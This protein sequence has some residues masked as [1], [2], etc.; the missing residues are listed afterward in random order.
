MMHAKPDTPFPMTPTLKFHVTTG[1]YTVGEVIDLS[2]L[3]TQIMIDFTIGLADAVVTQ[4]S[5]Q[6]Y[7]RNS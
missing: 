7:T 2:K 3:N 1:T 5:D 4:G 6:R